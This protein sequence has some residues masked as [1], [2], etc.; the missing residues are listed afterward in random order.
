MKFGGM[1]P[2][3]DTRIDDEPSV[4]SNSR[5]REPLLNGPVAFP[6]NWISSPVYLSGCALT[7]ETERYGFMNDRDA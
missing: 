1:G 6:I 2:E 5:S 4:R 3:Y 7:S